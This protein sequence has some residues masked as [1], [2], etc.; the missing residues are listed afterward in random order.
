MGS[1]KVTVATLFYWRS[2]FSEND[3]WKNW[4]T[5]TSPVMAFDFRGKRTAPLNRLPVVTGKVTPGDIRSD[6]EWR[7]ARRHSC[8]CD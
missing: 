7:K 8:N 1:W 2:C 6:L 4:Y 5:V 3:S